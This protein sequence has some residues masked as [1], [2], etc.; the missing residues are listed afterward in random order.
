MRVNN[1]DFRALISELRNSDEKKNLYILVGVLIA[2]VAVAAGV[3]AV[4]FKKHMEEN[5]DWDEDVFC[6]D[7]FECD[8]DCCCCDFEE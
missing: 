2:V 1:D 7:D 8:D 5:E 3:A 6:D 4:L